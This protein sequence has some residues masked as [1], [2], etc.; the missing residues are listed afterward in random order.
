MVEEKILGLFRRQPD[1]FLSGEQ[2]SLDLNISRSAV[3]KYIEK[4]RISGYEFDAVP[5]LGYRLRKIPD[6]LYPQ[7]IRFALKTLTFGKEVI[8]Y[9]NIDSTNTVAY[10]LAKKGSPEGL[11][12]IAEG[13]TKG[14]GRL[15]REW[16]SPKQKGIYMSVILRPDMTPF[17][18]PK[19]TLLAAVSTALGIREDIG[20]PALIKWPNDILINQK[21]IGGI[22]TEMEAEQ[23][24]VNFLI[25]GIGINVNTRH[26]ELPKGASSIYEEI[27]SRVSRIGLAKAILEKLDEN[28]ELFKKEGFSPIKKEWRNLSATLGRRV[29]VTCMHESIEGEAVDIDSD[30]ALKIR[31]D[32]GFYERVLAGDLLVLR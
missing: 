5:H 23:D 8:Y 9:D 18:A 29:R 7:E 20:A 21:K 2:I 32:N 3:W 11:V 4:L 6:R 16:V 14:K 12:V 30:G 17:Q 1:V 10:D 28:Y 31:L 25:L 13:Q 24:S 26:S 27:G 22:L 19:I 15:S